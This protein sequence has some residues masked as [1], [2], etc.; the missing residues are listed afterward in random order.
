MNKKRS[1]LPYGDSTLSP[2]IKSTENEVA[3]WK[4]MQKD[5][6][7]KYFNAK[8]QEILEEM[9][10]LKDAW[11]VDKW[12]KNAEIAFKPEIG[13]S[14]Y[15]YERINGT[16]FISLIGPREWNIK[17]YDITFLDTVKINSKGT[18]TNE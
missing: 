11:E 6:S 9:K 13:I 5:E 18:W 4:E 3:V 15:A 10:E 17:K 7:N 2:P 16:K 14:Y 8:Y 12:V 1:V